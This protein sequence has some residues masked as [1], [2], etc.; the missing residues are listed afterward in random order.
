M[1]S[2]TLDSLSL[3]NSTRPVYIGRYLSL[4]ET[5]RSKL[6]LIGVTALL[7]ACKYEEVIPVEV[8]VPA[9]LLCHSTLYQQ[10]CFNSLHSPFTQ[11][12][13]LCLHH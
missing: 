10:N 6:Q 3:L 1:F 2:I 12:S 8:R 4:V 9:L 5:N 7:I 13:G 11:G